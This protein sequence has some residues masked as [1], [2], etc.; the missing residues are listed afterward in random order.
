MQPILSTGIWM[1]KFAKK[2]ILD[3]GSGGKS[4]KELIE[5]LFLPF[6]DNPLLRRMDD[7]AVFEI[8]GIKFAFSTDSYTVNPIIFPGGN[9]GS[10]A[11]H[12]TVNDLATQGAKPLYL[13]VG[14]ILEEGFSGEILK[15]ILEGMKKAAEEAHVLIITG[16]TKV[17]PRGQADKIFINTTG[18]GVVKK[19]HISG[20][21]AQVGDLILING[22][23]GDHG[24]CI[25]CL[26]EG[27]SLEMP[28]KSDT[29]PLNGLVEKILTITDNIHTMRDPTRGGV[30]TTL[31]EIAYQSQ[32]GI[33]IWE[34]ALPFKKEV[35]GAGELLG[36]DPLYLAN[37]GKMLIF[38]EKKEADKVLETMRNHS[39]GKEAAIIGEVKA[40]PKG[41]VWLKTRL[42]S[43]RLLDMLVGEAL[44]R[45]C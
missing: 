45:I 44:P 23:I 5:T 28:L 9:I 35:L 16:D 1:E 37:E 10:L 43:K 38:I 7:S 6:F 8:N 30:A 22:S 40:E 31:N 34:E 18:I 21:N 14:F 42:G 12:G 3:H 39:Y 13:S 25:L 32:V 26:Q 29:A 4:S 41:K 36:I 24:M 2:I 33:E 11:I 27:L 19:S 20:H 15:K 17:V